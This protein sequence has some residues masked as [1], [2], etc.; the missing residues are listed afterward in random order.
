[1]LVVSACGTRLPDSAFVAAGEE[2]AASGAPGATAS[3]ATGPQT[4]GGPTTT[5]PGGQP[6][7]GQPAAGQPAAGGAPAGGA[8]AGQGGQPA[9]GGPNQASDVGVTETEIV[10]GNITA[11][12]GVLGN[13]FEPTLLGLETYVSWINDNGG[14]RGRTL[15]L[16]S[17]NDN[18]DKTRDLQCGQDLVENKKV[19]AFVANNT[20]AEGGAAGYIDSKGVPVFAD[21]P[22]TNAAYRFPHYW[23]IYG[24]GCPKDGEHVCGNDKLYS[25]TGPYRWFK[26][27]LGVSNAAVFYYGLIG[28]SKQAADFTMEGLR[29]EGYTVTGYDVN[30][31]NPDFNQPVQDMQRKGV[32]IIYDVIDDGANRKLCDS[33]QTYSFSVQAKVSTVVA[34][35]DEVGTNFSEVCRNSIYIGGSSITY[36]DTSNPAVKQ[37]RDAFALYQPGAQLHQWALEGWMAGRA[38]VEG[39]A[40][41]GPSPTREGLESWLKSWKGY[42]YGGLTNP[43]DHQPVDYSQTTADNDCFTVA[44]WQDE[45][46]GWV[47]RTQPYD[48]LNGV[49][50]YPT[51]VSERGD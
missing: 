27:K 17:C 30:F 45:S 50:Q 21:L 11:V 48:C 1:M 7:A 35:G 3:G 20:R 36:S 23:S 18:E 42:T 29:Q 25:T 4:V 16:E 49:I 38:F 15:R 26:D 22:I 9:A 31:G 41:M 51:P 28:S 47:E 37:F 32:D 2:V 24:S 5:A 12:D 6:A 13:A 19:F 43:I 14:V 8:P 46:N 44:Q 39:I 34:Y 33:M 10:I 40:T